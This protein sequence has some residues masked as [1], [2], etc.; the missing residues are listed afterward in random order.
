MIS[1]FQGHVY[2]LIAWDFDA[3]HAKSGHRVSILISLSLASSHLF[4]QYFI[5]CYFS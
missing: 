5:L 1:M 2:H 3:E 4:Y